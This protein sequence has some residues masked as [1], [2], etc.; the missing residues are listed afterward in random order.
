MALGASITPDCTPPAT[1]AAVLHL[2]EDLYSAACGRPREPGIGVKKRG[3]RVYL[4][5]PRLERRALD[6]LLTVARVVL[7]AMGWKETASAS[8]ADACYEPGRREM[9]LFSLVWS[10]ARDMERAGIVMER[11]GIVME[12]AGIVERRLARQHPELE[13]WVYL[14][15]HLNPA[16]LVE[17]KRRLVAAYVAAWDYVAVDGKPDWYRPSVRP[18]PA[19]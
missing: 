8:Q 7:H 6:G 11:A 3:N 12:R 9:V 2:L 17:P 1:A 19:A 18:G 15:P 4:Y 5:L 14:P 13:G 10:G 16:S